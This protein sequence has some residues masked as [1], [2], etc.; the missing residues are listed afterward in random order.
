M[1]FLESKEVCVQCHLGHTPPWS[2]ASLWVS[3]AKIWSAVASPLSFLRLLILPS[4]RFSDSHS[5]SASTFCPFCSFGMVFQGDEKGIALIF[6]EILMWTVCFQHTDNTL[7]SGRRVLGLCPN[8]QP[9]PLFAKQ[10]SVHA[11]GIP[12]YWDNFQQ[13]LGISENLVMPVPQCLHHTQG[14]E[15]DLILNSEHLGSLQLSNTQKRNVLV[16]SGKMYACLN[17]CL[18]QTTCRV[19]TSTLISCK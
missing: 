7:G 2:G 18:F 1:A 11:A 8:I 13:K 16:Q 5:M 10:Q 4:G 12:E 9:P 3:C 19:W 6:L 15:G 14:S 17:V